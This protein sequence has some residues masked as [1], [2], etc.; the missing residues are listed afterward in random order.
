[1]FSDAVRAGNAHIIDCQIERVKYR[2]RRNCSVSY[3]LS[4]RDRSTGLIFEQRVAA[5]LFSGGESA[6][7]A[8]R[9][10]LKP[11]QSSLAGPALRLL[12]DLDMLTWWW[13]NDPK[14]TA[15]GI[16]A[17]AR[18][19]RE[20]V[21]PDL[22]AVLSGG[23]GMLLDYRLEVVQYVPEHRVCAWVDIRWTFNGL[24]NTQRVYA[25]S[26][27]EPD[28]STVHDILKAL[29]Q[30]QAWRAGRLRT[31]RALLWQP[32]FKLHWQQ[33]LPGQLLSDMPP[34]A[35]ARLAYPLG[36]QLAN[37]H[38]TEVALADTRSFA[39]LALAT[40]L[41]DVA[42][43]MKQAF[44]E[45]IQVIERLSDHLYRGLHTFFEAPLVTLHGDLH[46]CNV[47]ADGDQVAL[48]DLDGLK[49]GPAV[50][51]LGSW[52]A[53]GMY[54]A[55]LEGD[56]AMRDQP[57][58]RALLDG[59]IAAGG[60]RPNSQALVWATAWNLLCQ[61]A[62]RCVIGL[63]PGRLVMAP[64]LIALAHELVSATHLEVV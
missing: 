10:S 33:G 53:A 49:S 36:A 27:R 61:R 56:Q 34:L 46:S 7:R 14:L 12:P 13:P 37:L 15:P 26:S 28:G 52:L 5:R 39:P 55:I 17:D 50:L 42:Q 58:W 64:K 20:Q 40:R 43:V 19:M 22:V 2:P 3:L 11:I 44:P 41:N 32:A 24:T 54:R 60:Q 63:K 4:L 9:G 38:G 21:L 1:V 6:S 57:A 23:R 18:L 62:W 16:F 48:I 30:S 47:L 29:E 8:A 51:E 45:S 31:P 35:A 59:Y 25:K